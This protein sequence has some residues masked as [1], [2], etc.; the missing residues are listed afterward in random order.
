MDA[1]S[2]FF[3]MGGYGAFIWPA[4]ALV[5]VVL[6]GLLMVSLRTLRSGEADLEA[7]KE[8]EGDAAGET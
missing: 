5:S 8:N 7:L 3:A 1:I 2:T 4:Y 6:I